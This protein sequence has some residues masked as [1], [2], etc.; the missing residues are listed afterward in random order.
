MSVWAFQPPN[1]WPLLLLLPLGLILGGWLSARHRR[2]LRLEF[3]RREEIICGS[4][5][6]RRLRAWLSGLAIAAIGI[7]LLQPVAPGREAQIAP[8]VVLCVDVSRSMAAADLAPT[9]FASMQKQV[10]R[11]LAAGL[12]SRFALLAFAGDVQVVSP[13]TADRDAVGWL[14]SELSPGIVGTGGVGRGGTDIGA[15]VDT[16][17][18][19][20]RRVQSLGEIVLLTDGEDFMGNAALAARRAAGDGH[21]VHCIGYG[22][23]AGSKIVVERD[24]AQA[25][26]Q[27]AGGDDVVTCLNIEELQSIAT[28]GDGQFS[29]GTAPDVLADLWRQDWVPA[30]ARRLLEAGDGDVVPRFGLPLLVGLLL[31]ALRMCLMERRR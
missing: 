7:A 25:F 24:G 9:R 5:P 15:A 31:W 11:L 19:A 8:D 26:L 23:T 27:D 12:G 28:A 22:T 30:S 6:H 16:A 4:Q 20:L 10:R 1:W 2:G 21:R 17:A 18:A 3:G 29:I 14:L 13:M